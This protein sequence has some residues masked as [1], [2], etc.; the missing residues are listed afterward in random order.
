[1]RLLRQNLRHMSLFHR[2]FWT[3]FKKSTRSNTRRCRLLCRHVRCPCASGPI[4]VESSPVGAKTPGDMET[5]YVFPLKT[6]LHKAFIVSKRVSKTHISL[7]TPWRQMTFAS[8]ARGLARTAPLFGW[9]CSG[10]LRAKGSRAAPLPPQESIGPQGLKS[11]FETTTAQLTLGVPGPAAIVE[12]RP[13]RGTSCP[14]ER[15]RAVG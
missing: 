8:S 13:P 11:D 10:T 9:P 5:I 2:D 15:P 4:A 1:M 14:P 3:K 12:D 6:L 7:E